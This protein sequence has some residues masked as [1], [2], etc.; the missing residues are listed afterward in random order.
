MRCH[1][2]TVTVAAVLDYQKDE[3]PAG[4]I[5]TVGPVPCDKGGVTGGYLSWGGTGMGKG[6]LEVSRVCG[7]LAQVLCHGSAW[8]CT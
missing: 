4:H 1:V 7:K 8:R 5:L 2:A 3:V 6:R